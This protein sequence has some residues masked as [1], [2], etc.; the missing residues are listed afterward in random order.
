MEKMGARGAAV[1][2]EAEHLCMTARGVKKPG[3]QVVTSATR[4]IFREDPRTR[5]EFF[6]LLS[7]TAT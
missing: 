3:S 2:I 7:R 6:A 5:A 4:G 1:V